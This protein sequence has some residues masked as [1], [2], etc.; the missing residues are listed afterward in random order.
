MI[1]KRFKQYTLLKHKKRTQSFDLAFTKQSKTSGFY[2]PNRVTK[3][4]FNKA[5]ITLSGCNY[6]TKLKYDSL[7]SNFIKQNNNLF[8]GSWVSTLE[9]ISEK[10]FSLSIIFPHTTLVRL[11]FILQ[12]KL[13]TLLNANIR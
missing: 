5:S 12:A 8:P 10:S 2:I 4:I 6:Y 13:V 7:Y 11:L 3:T 1:K 9:K